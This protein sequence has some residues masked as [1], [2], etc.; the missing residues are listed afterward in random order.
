MGYDDLTKELEQVTAE[1][2]AARSAYASLGAKIAGLEAQRVALTKAIP[3][4][5]DSADQAVRLPGRYRTED[6]VEILAASG[7]D[8]SISKVIGALADA[9]RPDETY[10][11][12]SADLAYLAERGRI[13]RVSRGIY[14]APAE[15][16][17]E[18]D[19]IVVTLT[20]GNLNNRHIYLARHLT[21]FP[22][23][24]IGTGNKQGGRGRPL[25]VQFDGLDSEMETDITPDHKTFRTRDWHW[26][27]FFRRHNLR[28][29]D[30]VA[31]IRT[32]E[33]R[34]R[35]VPVPPRQSG[36]A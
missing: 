33:R 21:F 11:N 27:E 31:I 2:A 18:P 26:Q 35:I 6:I 36:P 9:G 8:M 19:R 32:A 7:A 34:Y 15:P 13:V 1:L 25:I 17:S 20:Q 5:S 30:K 29:G 23:D 3:H 14:A 16:H 10:D 22:D 12:V 24:A 4:T 28:A